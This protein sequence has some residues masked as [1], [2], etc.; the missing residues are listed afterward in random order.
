MDM[1]EVTTIT[2]MVMSVLP[3][4]W[5]SYLYYR[6]QIHKLKIDAIGHLKSDE[7]KKPVLLP[8]KE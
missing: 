7:N 2:A 1:N 6:L 4:L 3:V 5:I 8:K